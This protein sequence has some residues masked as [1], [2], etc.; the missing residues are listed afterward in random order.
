[1]YV[2]GVIG[3]SKEELEE[4]LRGM[5]ARRGV[6]DDTQVPAEGWRELVGEYKQHFKNKTGKEFPEDT[7]EQLRCAVGSVFGSWMAE[8]AGTYRRGERITGLQGT[9]VNVWQMLFDTIG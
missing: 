8:K 3:L 7:E 4:K 6:K 2:T 9:A 5:K 1:M